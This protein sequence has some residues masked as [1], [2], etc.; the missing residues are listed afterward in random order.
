MKTIDIFKAYNNLIES[1]DTDRIE[2]IL[3]RYELYKKTLNVPGDIFECGVFKGTSL[4]FWLKL[5]NIFE[6]TS[7]K[8][9]VGFD[10]FGDFPNST[11][12]FEKKSV[13]KF[14]K[15]SKF[16]KK[17]VYLDVKKKIKE[18]KLENRSQLIKGDIISTSKNYVK[19]HKGFRISLLHIDLD[20]YNGTKHA[21]ENFFPLVSKGGIVIFDEYGSRGWGESDAV[22][23]Y[24]QEK[25][26]KVI[27]TEFGKK[28][29]AYLVK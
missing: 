25:K 5:L 2:K 17:N 14:H 16:S 3:V 29:T 20:T 8:K 26:Y 13:K 27:R 28:P 23:E 9:V 4:I 22:D 11:L 10:T 1:D 7:F 6:P 19:N 12:K 24:F 21:L 18:A 15:E